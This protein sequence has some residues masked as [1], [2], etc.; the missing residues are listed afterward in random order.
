M[1]KIFQFRYD[2]LH[3]FLLFFSLLIFCSE[4]NGQIRTVSGTVSN[5]DSDRFEG[6]TVTVKGTT[7]STRTNADGAFD[8]EVPNGQ[9][10]VLTFSYVG[11]EVKEIAVSGVSA[12]RFEVVLDPERGSLE[13]VVVLGFGQSQK[14]IAQTGAIAS[15]DGRQLKQSPTANVMNALAGRLPGLVAVQRTGEPGK[16]DPALFI[17][18]RASLNTS[19]TPLVTIDGVQRDY[20]AISL[21][22]VNEIENIT[23]LKDASATAL[24]GVKGANGVI[25]VTTKSGKIGKPTINATLER[26]FS[27]AVE[28]PKF[29]DAYNTAILF[30]EGYKNDNPTATQPFYSDEAIEAFRTGSDPLRYANVDY[31]DELLK[32]GIE[33]RAN[34]N[35]SGGGQ[36][37]KYFVNVGYLDQGGIYNAEK[38]SDYDPNATYKRYNFR[39]NV[40]IDFDENFSIGLKLNGAIQNI[41][42]PNGSVANIFITAMTV[43][44]TIPIKYPVGY[45]SHDT[46]QANPFWFLNES[47]Y[48]EE[49]NSAM[50]GMFTAIRKLN[51]ITEG[52]S[53]KGN[54]SF[55][56]YYNNSLVRTK[57]VPR[58]RYNGTGDFNDTESYT[59]FNSDI[60]LSAPR[61]AFSQSRT[62]WMDASLNYQRRFGDH[63]VS[64]LLLAN[65]TQIVNAIADQNATNA[66]PF[67]SQGLVMR[68]VYNY[69][70]KYFAEFNAGYNGTDN[71]SPEKRYGFFPAASVGWL[72]SEENFMKGSNLINHLKVRAS[73][74]L[75]G[76]DQIA[77]RRWLFI[78]EYLNEGSYGYGTTLQNVAA[79]SEGAMANR[80][81]SWQIAEKTNV[82]VEL[83]AFRNM[84]GLNVD[85][86]YENRY[87]QLITPN[88]VPGILGMTG[89]NLPPV[90]EGK[91]ENKGFEIELTHNHRIGQVNYFLN[92]NTSFSRNKILFMD[93]AP[94][95]YPW[96]ARTGRSIGQYYGLTAIGFFRN[97][98]EINNSPTQFGTVIPG[99]LK[100][101]DLNNDGVIDGNDV[102]HIGGSNVPEVFFGIS[103]GANW[104]NFDVSF[105]FQ[106]AANAWRNNQGI[107]YWEFF[108]GGKVLEAHLGRWT[109]ETAAMATYPALHSVR[110]AN[111]HRQ[112]TFYLEDVRYIRLKNFE[113][114]YTFND[115][116]IIN[117][118]G[119][120]SWRIYANG[121]N[122]FTWKG[123]TVFDPELTG[124][125]N[126]YPTM[127]TFNLGTAI[128]F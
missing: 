5:Q 18:G 6:V 90:N 3:V 84:L 106:G 116:K 43:T 107:G 115:V 69:K 77:G 61:G 86:F 112:S 101:K 68:A 73:Y 123:D 33:T 95:L 58:I 128:S 81:V 64:G 85:L 45:Y 15:V 42:R 98:A 34:V 93:E 13:E 11:Y 91:V 97:Q 47:G 109:P 57:E 113:I 4:A 72:L 62:I 7:I 111:N 22:D 24:Y 99:D 122:L 51:F 100:Y 83:K 35:V 49:Y 70:Y 2:K 27:D 76:D 20:K 9:T 10:D 124:A 104:K 80:A 114:G 21:L 74:G 55:D 92:A 1:R 39:S 31:L 75:T 67:V 60:P 65:R 48:V 38:N 25:I 41:S 127:R 89:S 19:S 96:L 40:D 53:I 118:K 71:F 63:D 26:A 121:Q 105:L 46:Q 119:F 16:D 28:M 120:R 87:N 82:G 103:G 102:A 125:T 94:Q 126:T 30:N 44:P 88:T 56:G 8:I 29:L 32:T 50:S 117:H 52:L 79:I 54:Y 37:A 66:I 59:F 17:R 78:S 36:L 12:D 110:N 23:I 14:K 108:N